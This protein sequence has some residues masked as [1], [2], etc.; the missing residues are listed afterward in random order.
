MISKSGLIER[1]KQITIRIIC[2][3]FFVP[4]ML[5]AQDIHFSQFY[6]SPMTLNP[7]LAGNTHDIQANANYKNQWGSVTS[8]YKT[9]AVSVD[10]RLTKKDNAKSGFWVGA[11]NF[12]NDKAGDASLGTTQLNA[13]CGYYITTSEKSALGVAFQGGFANRSINPGVLTWGNQYNGYSLDPTL[14]SMEP[15]ETNSVFYWD[16]GGGINFSFQ[17]NERYMTG[18]DQ[19]KFDLGFA[20]FHV[21]RPEYSFYGGEEKLNMKFSA[22]WQALIGIANTN[23]SIV[24]GFFYYRQS[25]AKEVFMGTSF[26]YLLVESSRVTGLVKGSAL[27]LGAY[28]RTSDAIVATLLYEWNKY[29]IGISY[30]FN[31]SDLK[32]ASSGKG[33][34]EISL[35]FRSPNPFL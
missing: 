1:M 34:I 7:A 23:L 13:T 29:S 31:V 22:Y 2:A 20:F 21:P 3:L 5:N 30:D 33:G 10:G 6:M 11:L 19:F 24:P 32:D 15:A 14:P 17:E 4:F 25:P 16:L 28:Y 27:N 26:K 12:Y 9:I 8:P 18:N 35:R